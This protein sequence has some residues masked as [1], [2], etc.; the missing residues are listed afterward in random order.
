MRDLGLPILRVCGHSAKPLEDPHSGLYSSK[1]RM[2]VVEVWYRGEGK[3]E[4]R[5]CE[6]LDGGCQGDKNTRTVGVGAGVSHR[7]NPRTG[8][9]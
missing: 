2:L 7:Q 9:P 4:L 6:S 8:E 3:E 1:D 5:A